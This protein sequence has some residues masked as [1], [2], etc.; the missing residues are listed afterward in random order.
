MNVLVVDDEFDTESLFTQRFR[1]ELRNGSMQLQFAGSAEAALDI[2]NRHG[3]P[4]LVL[5]LSDINLPGV[6]GI[7]LLK[8]LKERYTHPTVYMI[9]PSDDMGRRSAAEQSGVDGFLSKPLDFDELRRDV[10][11]LP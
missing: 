3:T 7:D 1:R 9:A 8:M 6:S 5:I 4:D 11:R 2:M 10:L